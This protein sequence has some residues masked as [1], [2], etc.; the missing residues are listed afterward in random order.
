MA[1]A[2]KHIEKQTPNPIEEQTQALSQLLEA[3]AQSKEAL[4]VFLDILQELHNAGL[5]DIVQG[6]LKTRHRVGRIA[7]QQMDQPS[8]HRMMKNG[9]IAMQFLGKLDPKQIESILGGFEKGLKK[10]QETNQEDKHLGLWGIGK[11]LR[12][13]NVSASLTAM[14]GFLQGMGE[15]FT[16]ENKNVH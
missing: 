12:D 4:V 14:L 1:K 13:P 3:T 10:L 15:E 7:V 5:L 11:T 16:K 6:L 8:M 2:I 9:V